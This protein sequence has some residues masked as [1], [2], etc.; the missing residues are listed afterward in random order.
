MQ[1]LFKVYFPKKNI[2]CSHK[3]DALYAVV[4][5]ASIIAKVE[6]DR[7]VAKISEQIGIPIGSGYPND[8]VTK[9]FLREYLKQH[10]KLPYFVR[11]SWKTASTLLGKNENSK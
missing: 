1:F 5:A 2:I 3:A 11:M 6:R 10:G 8:P 9:K 4:G 7:A